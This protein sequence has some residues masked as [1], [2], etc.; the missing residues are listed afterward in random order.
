MKETNGA[1]Q[2]GTARNRCEC[3]YSDEMM[4][5]LACENT[6]NTGATCDKATSLKSNRPFTMVDAD[7][8]DA[9]ASVDRPQSHGDQS[10]VDK[11]ESEKTEK[12]IPKKSRIWLPLIVLPYLIGIAWH[13]VH[14][15]ASI[16]TGNF[17]EARR[18]YIDENSLDPHHFLLNEKYTP[19][20]P[21]LG[22]SQFASSL[23]QALEKKRDRLSCRRF[24][25]RTIESTTSPG[26]GVDDKKIKSKTTI[27]VARII[28]V[29]NA[30]T[31]VS[32]A[33]VLVIPPT[34]NWFA[35]QFHYSILQLIHRLSTPSV[36]PWLAKTI[37]IVT[38][39]TDISPDRTVESFLQLYL[40][41]SDAINDWTDFRQY[42]GAIVRN[43]IVLDA[44]INTNNTL[45]QSTVQKPY[46]TMNELRILPQGRR[47]VL[48]NMDLV[49]L[50]TTVYARANMFY[51]THGQQGPGVVMTV[52]PY[53]QQVQSLWHTIQPY[54]SPKLHAWLANLLQFV[55][56]ELT[57]LKGP[58]PP[59]A[60]ALD[61]G[62]DSITIQAVFTTDSA[63]QKQQFFLQLVAKTEPIL[64]ALSNLHERLHH[65]TSLY[66]LT[67]AERFVKHEE[68]LVP[69][70]L[71]ITPLVI[72]A[73]TLIL[74][75]INHFHPGAVQHALLLTLIGTAVISILSI[76]LI[77]WMGKQA[78]IVST[79][80]AMWYHVATKVGYLIVLIFALFGLPK[81]SK[82]FQ[83]V[84]A[85]Q[86][87][88]FAACLLAIYIHVPIAFG[89]VSLAFPSAMLWSP[90]IAFST[91]RKKKT[92]P[93]AKQPRGFLRLLTMFRYLLKVILLVFISPFAL[94]PAI[95]TLYTPYVLYA[96]IP[97]HLM[98]S[99]MWLLSE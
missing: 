83:S 73:V 42:A 78:G 16:F 26:G 93:D 7:Q 97:L 80:S 88:Q 70:L 37:L 90:I 71:V 84:S 77:E 24:H 63:E 41:S 62:I 50:C 44:T 28:P 53:N 19:L 75:D 8:V 25:S 65:S 20:R 67:S 29:A 54:T 72:R 95:L 52:H 12:E 58:S 14:P 45:T 43:L 55:A 35:S 98:T 66:L 49:F 92:T 30:V 22:K 81:Q 87:V 23:C 40:Q 89:H 60:I 9:T 64:R 39:N 82:G 36:T 94:V 57:L 18:W 27:E 11:L 79:P 69:N 4:R 2:D 48:P 68:Y 59:H 85:R 46:G 76:S 34:N 86:S 31:P 5:R 56:F 21:E 15:I 74:I 33:L 32:E 91:F 61:H 38:S 96:Y 99:I 6:L 13:C 10:T 47:G 1:R 3:R 51:H 17:S